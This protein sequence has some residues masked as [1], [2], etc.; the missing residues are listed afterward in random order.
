[1]TNGDAIR[2]LDAA[3]TRSADAARLREEYPDAPEQSIENAKQLD[4]LQQ[5]LESLMA[6]LKNGQKSRSSQLSGLD[7]AV[8][9]VEER[10]AALA[11]SAGAATAGEKQLLKEAQATHRN[12]SLSDLG[13]VFDPDTNTTTRL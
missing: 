8:N 1:M 6:A 9:S 4:A 11:V 12:S 13:K 7:Q 10:M 3:L 5:E 2:K